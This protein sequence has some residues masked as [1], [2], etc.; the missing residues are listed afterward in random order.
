MK[1]TYLLG[2][3]VLGIVSLVT[4][5][6]ILIATGVI[7]GTP[8]RI[9]FTS[10][11][12]QKVYDGEALV[13]N[14]YKDAWIS[15]GE[16]KEGHRYEVS[17]LGTQT[18]AGTSDNTISVKI[19]DA[20]GADVTESYD[21]EYQFG[22]LTVNPRSI[23]ITASSASKQYDTEKLECKEWSLVE[24]EVLKDHVIEPNISDSRTEVGESDN[25]I[26][27]RVVD[28]S[29]KDV[30]S[31]YVIT[32]V[33]GKLLVTPHIITIESKTTE[34]IYDATPLT[35]ID[36][37]EELGYEITAGG[38]I[39]GHKE[40]VVMTGTQTEVGK[41]V[42]TFGVKIVDENGNDVTNCYKV[43]SVYGEL[44]VTKKDVTIESDSAEKIYD[45]KPLELPS[46]DETKNYTIPAGE[47]VEGHKI[48]LD[49]T[50]SQTEAGSSSNSFGYEIIDS[51]GNTVTHNY[52]VT[53]LFGVLKVTPLDVTVQSNGAEKVYDR[54][55][56]VLGSTP[57]EKN[58]QVI[59]GSILEEHTLIVNLTGEQTEVGSS[60]NTFGYEIVDEEGISVT[61]NYNVTTEFGDL[62]V[63]PIDITIESAD[64]EKTYDRT[65]LFLTSTPEEPNYVITAG[66]L[67]SGDTLN[68]TL[69]GTQKDAG[70]SE[71][72][73]ACE[74]IDENGNDVTRNY[75]INKMYGTLTVKPIKLTI[76]SEGAEKVYDGEPLYL[77][78][79][80]EAPNFSIIAG[81]LLDGHTIDVVFSGI[82][83]EVGS[84]DNS[85]SYEIFD[86][87]GFVI[88]SNYDV[89][90]LYGKLVVKPIEITISSYGASKVYD[91]TAL[92]LKSTRKEP[93][94][95]IVAG[96]LMD[97]HELEVIFTGAQTNVG[98]SENTF[99]CEITDSEGNDVTRNYN[100][101]KICGELTVLPLPI[102]V[103]SNGASKIYDATP[104]FLTST[105]SEPNYEVVSG[106]L[107][108]GHYFV[109]KMTGTITN[110]GTTENKFSIEIENE[111][112]DY[113][114]SNYAITQLYGELRVDP[115]MLT[116]T[117][118]GAKKQYDATPLKLESTAS[119]P[120]YTLVGELVAG[121]KLTVEMTGSITDVGKENNAFAY[122]ITDQ[123]GKNVTKNYEVRTVF[124]TL[125]VTKR[126]ITLQSGIK[127]GV[128][129]DGVVK[130]E[131]ITDISG[132]LLPNHTILAS[133]NEGATEVGDHK[134]TFTCAIKEGDK[135]VSANYDITYIYGTLTVT[136][137]PLTVTSEDDRKTYDGT[138]LTNSNWSVT[139]STKPV[140]TH[141]VEV[142]VT[143][144]ITDPG[145]KPNTISEVVIYDENGEKV[146][147]NYEIRTVEGVLTVF[148]PDGSLPGENGGGSSGG[149]GLGKD[150]SLGGGG[151]TPD[152][153]TVV[154]RLKTDASTAILM[155]NYSFGSYN[156]QGWDQA[157]DYTGTGINGTHALTYLSGLAIG[158][159]G[160]SQIRLDVEPLASDYVLPSYM[161]V[162]SLNYQ[163]QTSDRSYTGST[164][165]VYS[166]YFYDYLLTGGD[167]SL[168]SEYLAIERQYRS[169]VYANYL[170]IPES[171]NE[172][173]QGII[174]EAGLSASDPEILTKV[175]AYIRSSA[176]YN[177]E[178]DTAMDSEDDVVV[179]FLSEYKEGVCRHYAAAGTLLFRALGIP[180]RYTIG[181][182]ASTTA[183]EWTDVKAG[184][185][186]AWVEVY[187]DGI[188]WIALDVTGTGSGSDGDGG[189]DG[190][191]TDENALVITPDT[192][193]KQYD[194][195]PL[196]SPSGTFYSNGV[197]GNDAFTKLMEEG[198]T[199]EVTFEQTSRTDPGETGYSINSFIL[200]DPDG[201]NVTSSFNITKQSGKIKITAHQIT[202]TS[203]DVYAEYTGNI[204][205]SSVSDFIY[206]ALAEPT[207]SIEIYNIRQVKNAGSVRNTFSVRITD[208]QGNDITSTYQINYSYGTIKVEKR[209]LTLIAGSRTWVWDFSSSTEYS[210][211]SY[212][213]GEGTSLVSSDKIYSVVFSQDSVQIGPGTTEN[214]ITSVK[215]VNSNGDDVTS[216]YSITIQKGTLTVT[217]E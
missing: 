201:N 96:A 97:G 177:L 171:T 42:N 31:N 217:I 10:A 140:S 191:G 6:V 200:Y 202:V 139:S 79:T 15:S 124:G 142:A 77:T 32:Y 11:S 85:F 129:G 29:G 187:I 95:E 165:S 43:T 104:L 88:T 158:N 25:T 213:I 55:P 58:Y 69:T 89:R 174:N 161:S 157:S 125:E 120:N 39:D 82:Q 114:T 24:G 101:T 92:T 141:T 102:S 13:A 128:Y 44:S 34:K 122:T 132:A 170:D 98:T 52:N 184:Q 182:A 156:G 23:K 123:N 62:V 144:T 116:I 172:F 30:S 186:H 208:E 21:I 4:V 127:T 67:L 74:I 178:Y 40:V 65:P 166:L 138:A 148:N 198:Y 126:P 87:D 90:V 35:F 212:S 193:S 109:I 66:E 207:H 175:Q 50:G 143:G 83:T 60:P 33:P 48:I 149:G 84:S 105:T 53:A 135:N 81:A 27:A 46:T 210:Y 167:L 203:P 162:N 54:L 176:K 106:E 188:G 63:K 78:N 107:L 206:T 110:V 180:A 72:T 75:N 118:A 68:V 136:K 130:N 108:E 7:G 215:I 179:A 211:H 121:H 216:C 37:K 181:Y 159:S 47:I 76:V 20:N 192:V 111:D 51:E 119:T 1:K 150:G 145:Q 28:L 93:N 45:G 196:Y 94:Y 160:Y 117:S 133:F 18:D 64:A 190:D 59:A 36:N 195:T 152:M 57:E 185:A 209:E 3:I 86:E 17:V 70:T 73:F 91:R 146:T 173:M 204:V 100:I 199:Y 103:K 2:S 189:G 164:D 19:F 38:L 131:S 22:K 16:L 99:G 154:Y 12:A 147:H 163:I 9:V 134:N 49:V 56:L 26:T 112:G 153:Q 71:N 14:E 168:P 113:V 80:P 155:R 169:F 205:T 5:M 197:H 8:E 214:I 183:G 61:H 151:G 41:S 194:G 137:R 115:V